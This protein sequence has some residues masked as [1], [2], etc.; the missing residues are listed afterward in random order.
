MDTAG[1]AALDLPRGRVEAFGAAV[2]GEEVSQT[3]ELLLVIEL[4][5]A[6]SALV[7]VE[8]ALHAHQ[9]VALRAVPLELDLVGAAVEV[10]I[11]VH[12]K[13][14]AGL[15]EFRRARREIAAVD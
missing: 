10:L 2:D 5:R 6:D 11:E 8:R 1:Q 3:V 7:L 14:R 12:A 9:E 4:E 15:N 13:G